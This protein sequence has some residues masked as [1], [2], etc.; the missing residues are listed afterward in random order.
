MNP[1][2]QQFGT[3]IIEMTKAF[4]EIRSFMSQSSIYFSPPHVRKATSCLF[5]YRFIIV[6]PLPL[7]ASITDH[8]VIL[9]AVETDRLMTWACVNREHV[10]RFIIRNLLQKNCCSALLFTIPPYIK[11]K[12][13]V[14]SF[15]DDIFGDFFH[16]FYML[17]NVICLQGIRH[18]EIYVFV[19]CLTLNSVMYR[20]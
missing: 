5:A 13:C 6:R 9:P 18:R 19:N 8:K 17:K 11:R 1:E 10:N 15:C 7:K 20:L 14:P 12:P 3:S 16:P 2:I 4:H